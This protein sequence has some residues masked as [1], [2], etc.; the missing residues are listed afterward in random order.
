LITGEDGKEILMVMKNKMVYAMGKNF[1]GFLGTGDKNSTLYPRK[2]DALCKKNI[3]TF[4]Y[5]NGSHILALT[6]E[7][8]VRKLILEYK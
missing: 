5:G 8:E 4:A 2:V 7:G 6:N 3:K 1:N